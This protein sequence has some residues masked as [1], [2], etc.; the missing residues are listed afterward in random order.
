[1]HA[2]KSILSKSTTFNNSKKRGV[3]A[4]GLLQKHFHTRGN[5]QRSYSNAFRINVNLNSATIQDTQLRFYRF[6]Y[7]M[8]C[9]S[10][11]AYR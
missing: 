5:E 2:F 3:P 6:R 8:I 10:S 7:L 9:R 1:M 11:D 4:K